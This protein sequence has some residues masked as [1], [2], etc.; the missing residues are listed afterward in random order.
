M[1]VF[2]RGRVGS[3][4]KSALAAVLPKAVGTLVFVL[5]DWWDWW[6]W[7]DKKSPA[8]IRGPVL[9]LHSAANLSLSAG[10]SSARSIPPIKMR[11]NV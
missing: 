2:R 8:A 3:R 7:W 6:D 9:I 5:R 4:P 11:G 10:L 1:R